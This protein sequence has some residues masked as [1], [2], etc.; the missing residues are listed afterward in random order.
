MGLEFVMFMVLLVQ[1]FDVTGD[2]D[3]VSHRVQHLVGV[4]S[5]ISSVAKED[6][7]KAMISKLTL[8]RGCVSLGNDA[9]F[10]KYAKMILIFGWLTVKEFVRRLVVRSMKRDVV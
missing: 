9:D 2:P 4:T 1:P 5:M 3:F 8:D 10:T 6:A 7:N